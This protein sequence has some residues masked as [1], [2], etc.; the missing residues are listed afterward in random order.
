LVIATGGA[1]GFLASVLANG[2]TGQQQHARYVSAE[3]MD[4]GGGGGSFLFAGGGTNPGSPE[5]SP[6]RAVPLQRV[7]ANIGATTRD[8]MFFFMLFPLLAGA[9]PTL[10]QGRHYGPLSGKSNIFARFCLSLYNR[11]VRGVNIIWR[12]RRLK[13]FVWGRTL[14]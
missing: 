6:A 10:Y 14:S 9:E 8:F 13:G 12:N 3:D 1:G 5:P 4:L 2:V 11:N 7:T